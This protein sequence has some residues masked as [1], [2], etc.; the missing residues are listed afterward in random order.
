[1]IS[2]RHRIAPSA[3]SASAVIALFAD[4][5]ER[6]M[7]R[8]AIPRPEIQL[9]IRFGPSA[10]DG[11]DAHAFGVRERAHRKLI[12]KGQRIVTARLH[13]GATEAVLGVS[14][15][16]IAGRIVALDDLWGDAAT[17][18]LLDRLAGAHGTVDAASLLDGAI[19]ERL[20]I[21]NGRR[22][23]AQLAIDA[24]ARLTSDNVNTVA[25]D[26]G[27]SERHLRRVFREAVGVS[28]KAFA[29]LVRFH[30]ALRAAG[31]DD[32]ASWA[33]IAAGAGYYDQAHLIAEFRAIAGV[34]P[35][36]LLGELRVAGSVEPDYG[37]SGGVGAKF[38]PLK[39]SMR[40]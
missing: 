25:G 3:A 35:R 18:R 26:L 11:L 13:F 1:M 32:R 38:A 29:R 33:S 9:V 17:R 19:A 5:C 15:S 21:T 37:A 7:Q 30:R 16:D 40:P 14:A 27:V 12:R 36:A 20:A 4:E 24:A 22:G 23:H 2:Q 31:E 39:K 28:P 10:R 6:D 34:T 8:V